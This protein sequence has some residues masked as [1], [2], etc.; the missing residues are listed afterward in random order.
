MREQPL[1]QIDKRA[2]VVWKWSGGITSLFS[3]ILV[4]GLFILT[5]RFDW[6]WWV[7]GSLG[8]IALLET[9]LLV[10]VLPQ[11]TWSSWRYEIRETEIDL[12]RGIIFKQRTIIPMVRIQH[13]DTH[14]GP[15]MRKYGLSSVKFST[16]AGN[17]EIPALANAQA[18]QVRDQI[19]ELARVS[20]ED[21]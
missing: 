13:V 20:H 10:V 14:Q 5:I 3:W 7:V 9:L 11:R 6:T 4:I 21:I 12:Q 15:L 1:Q 2:L 18:D 17:H 16:A 19:A 8:L